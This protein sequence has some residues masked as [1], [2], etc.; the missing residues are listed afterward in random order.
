[1][2]GYWGRPAE[3]VAVMRGGW[4]LTGDVGYRDP[5]GYFYI[6]D[7]KK[8]MVLVNGIN[9]YPREVEEVIYQFPG[10]REAAV[11]G[12]PDARRGEQ[13]RAFVVALE[14]G[15]V[16]TVALQSF[17]RERLADYKVPRE[18]VLLPALPRN[19]TGKVLKTTLRTLAP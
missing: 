3:T 14:G 16:D 5:E 10:V 19:A 4:L 1:M 15:T 6:T 8:D 12:V 7:R 2:L 9:V 18:I 17:L 13:A 11:V